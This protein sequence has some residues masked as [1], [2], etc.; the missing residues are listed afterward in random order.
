MLL[1]RRAG[2]L[3]PDQP[4]DAAAPKEQEQALALS[5]ELGGLP[6]ALD[7]A[8]AFVAA[9]HRR[10]SWRSIA[11]CTSE[12]GQQLRARRGPHPLAHPHV[13]ETFSLAFAQVA[14]RNPAAADLLR[15]CAFLH[16][17]AIPEE[18][19]IEGAPEWGEPL[20]AVLADPLERCALNCSRPSTASR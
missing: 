16:P 10:Q 9:N 18:L 5:A 13:T 8:G 19:L 2:R 3:R 1:L 15:A 7:Q 14:A 17:D 4:L 11:T 12:R 20:A 6:L